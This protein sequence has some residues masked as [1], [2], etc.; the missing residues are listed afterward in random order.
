M[1]SVP[2][3]SVQMT[4]VAPIVSQA[5]SLR[6]R[7]FCLSILRML[8]AR[9]TV[10]LSGSPSGTATTTSVTAMRMLSRKNSAISSVSLLLA[11]LP[12]KRK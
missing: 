3:L 9:L 4:V 2:V 12:S 8:S 1:V 5:W 6:T 7:L 10:T 11:T